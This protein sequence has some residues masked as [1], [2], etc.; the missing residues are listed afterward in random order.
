V[1]AFDTGPGEH[2]L[3]DLAAER[4]SGGRLRCD[5]D[6][7]LAQRGQVDAGL[8]A[9]LLSDEFFAQNA[10]ALDGRERFGHVLLERIIAREAAGRR[11]RLGELDRD[12]GP[13]SPPAPSATRIANG[14]S[15]AAWT[16]SC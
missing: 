2:A 6:G 8:L 7:K 14:S 16:K 12:A 5:L 9:Q 1:L 4:A 10:A 3:L 13:R 11:S 15:R